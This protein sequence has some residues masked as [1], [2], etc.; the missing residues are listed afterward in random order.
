[1]PYLE[2]VSLA[3]HTVV[4]NQGDASDGVYLIQQGVLRASYKFGDT[5]ASIE[6]SMVPGTLAGELSA[7]AG[8]PRNATVFVES[9]AILWKLTIESMSTLEEVDPPLAR[10]FVKL[11]LKCE[12]Y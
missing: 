12:S 7:L 8:L 5:F 2:R 1:M 11:I 6:E 3:T 10:L 4:W 9:D